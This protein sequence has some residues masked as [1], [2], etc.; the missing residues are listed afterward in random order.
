MVVLHTLRTVRLSS[1]NFK[2]ICSGNLICTRG[3]YSTCR[4]G[5]QKACEFSDSNNT[6]LVDSQISC[7][8]G[9]DYR[10]SP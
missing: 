2:Q 10:E 9:G 3:N 1:F 5:A 7:S 4:G 6:Q 8:V